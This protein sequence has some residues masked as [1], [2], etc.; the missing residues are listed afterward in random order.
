M[1][2]KAKGF[3]A[4]VGLAVLCLG[5]PAFGQAVVSV[6]FT[7]GY[8]TT[9]EDFGAG[10]YSAT[11]NGASSPGIICDDFN[12]EVTSGEKWNANAYEASSLASGNLGNT[13]FGGSI[14]L[15]GYAEVAT[16]VSLMFGN[17]TS[18]GA[19]TGITQSELSSAIWD[20]TTPGGISGLDS[21]ANALV[22]AVKLAFNGNLSGATAYLATLTNLWILT[23]DPK[24]GV[25]SGEP[26]EMWTENLSVPEGG[27]A[28]LYLTLAG[29]TCFGAMF[30]RYVAAFALTVPE[31]GSTLLYLLLA[32]TSCFGA[33]FFSIRSK[34]R[35]RRTA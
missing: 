34:L 17:G 2:I 12:D 23:P 16:L 18:Y 35:S 5:V 14:G 22:A 27:A 29:L 21:K 30:F 6:D 13:L 3:A 9:F 10:I 4:I 26:Q 7:G 15:T 19:I 8:T 1:K 32:G 24:T 20:L 31:G 25:G 33:M 28:L 11:I